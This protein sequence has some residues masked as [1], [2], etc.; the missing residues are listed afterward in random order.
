MAADRAIG[1][2]G[3]LTGSDQGFSHTHLLA[4]FTPLQ[5]AE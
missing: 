5:G 1:G 3:L 4:T 2:D